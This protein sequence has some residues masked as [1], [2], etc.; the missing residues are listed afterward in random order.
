MNSDDLLKKWLN[1]DL[2]EAEAAAFAATGDAAMYEEIVQEAQRFMASD[3][4]AVPDF[5][6]LEQRLAVKKK[7]TYPWIAAAVA[8][9][10]VL[11][12]SIAVYTYLGN[13]EIIIAATTLGKNETIVLPDNSRVVLNEQSQLDY[14][15]DTW[16]TERTL[17][18]N[19]EAFFKVEK[20]ARFNVRTPAGEVHVLGTQFNVLT[21]EN[22]FTVSC[23]EGLVQVVYKNKIVKV[24]AGAAFTLTASG[25]VQ[26]DVATTQPVWL[27]SMSV[28]NNAA[29]NKVILALEKQ[30]AVKVRLDASTQGRFT[31]A[32][33]NDNLDNALK[34]IT[35]PFNMT[36]SIV[37]DTVIINSNE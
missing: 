32:F 19:G 28:F 34:A 13:D 3:H 29:F 18:L 7:P 16:A 17:N 10:A 25:I 2:S 22:L 8:M 36:Y 15:A 11:I 31:G 14:N 9:A 23:Y 12:T 20:G 1:N 35:Q 33:E 6:T 21:R 4:T 24:P 26:S 37:N 5:K 27:N 30:Y